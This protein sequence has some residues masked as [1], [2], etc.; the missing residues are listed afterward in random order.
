MTKRTSP[1]WVLGGVFLG[2][3]GLAVAGGAGSGAISVEESGSGDAIVFL[4]GLGCRGAVWNAVSRRLSGCHNVL[5][6][7]G[8]FG[9]VPGTQTDFAVVRDAVAQLVQD[10]HWR[11]AVLVGHSFGG[12]LALALAVSRPE[13]F[14]KVVIL[15]AYPFP[16]AM[17]KPDMTPDGARQLAAAMRPV[18][19]GLTDEQFRMQ[20]TQSL[21]M[22]ITEEREFQMVLSWML[23]SDRRTIAEAQFE[24]LS[25]D[26]RPAIHNIQCPL[27]V[28]GSWRGRESLGLT[29]DSVAA[30]LREQYR[31]APRCRIEISRSARHFLLLDDPEWVA[32]ADC[33]FHR[34]MNAKQR[35]RLFL[36]L[37][38]D[39]R[40][41]V[42][43]LCRGYLTSPEDAED[44]F[45]EIMTRVWNSLPEFRGEARASTWERMAALHEAIA[46]LAEQDRL[47][48]TLLLEGLS[49]KEIAEITGITVNYVGV[50]I[51]RIKQALEKSLR[52]SRYGNV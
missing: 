14:R 39:Y 3:T 29:R 17:V 46:A 30:T 52:E 1:G 15:D 35:E 10:K 7:I 50:K 24:A 28:L 38:R 6:S 33:G 16:A 47:I 21:R 8:G 43:R 25:T 45:Q 13:L 48:A 18:L 27:L 42:L 23:A 22:M 51:T 32:A 2:I 31:T 19:A 37:F 36:E 5:V 44:L 49:C 41:R 34:P 4:P 11:N 20:Q 9:G 40:E 26:L 12:N